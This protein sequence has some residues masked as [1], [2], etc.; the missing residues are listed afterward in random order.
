MFLFT[1]RKLYEKFRDI[2][3]GMWR[4]ENNTYFVDGTKERNN[5]TF[6]DW[7]AKED[8]D[9]YCSS[10]GPSKKVEETACLYNYRGLCEIPVC[11]N[12]SDKFY[13]SC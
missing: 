7:K 1:F 4:D 10:I 5:E 12:S 13:A 9:F 8:Y 2:W 6:V 3:I 11:K